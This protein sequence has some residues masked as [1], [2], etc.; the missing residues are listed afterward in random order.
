[1][2]SAAA[3]ALAAVECITLFVISATSVTRGSCSKHTSAPTWP[4]GPTYQ[5]TL[6]TWNITSCNHHTRRVLASSFSTICGVLL[7]AMAGG[8]GGMMSKLEDTNG[9]AVGKWKA[10]LTA[11]PAHAAS[12]AGETSEARYLRPSTET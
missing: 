12:L 7:L 3:T 1:M 4:Q 10:A 2:Y 8:G 9:L 5:G 11:A 6:R